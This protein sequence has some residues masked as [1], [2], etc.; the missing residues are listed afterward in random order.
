MAHSAPSRPLAVIFGTPDPVLSADQRA[1]FRDA[2]PLGLI[3][4]KRNCESPDQ[5][6]R[7]CGDFRDAV[8]RTDAPVLIDFEG[9]EHQRMEPPV[10]P[11]FPA[12]AAFGR[13]YAGDALAGLRAARLNGAAIGTLL[14]RHGVTVDCAPLA[15]VPVAGADP[16]IG[17]RAFGTDPEVVTVLA[18]AFMDGM[19]SVG[20]TPIIKHIP[21]HGRALV[22]SHKDRPVVDTGLDMLDCTDFLPFARLNRTAPW[23][24]VAHVVYSAVDAANPASISRD[25]VQT[26]IRERIGFDGVLISDCIYMESLGGTLAERAAAVQGAGVDIVLSSHGDVDEWIPIAAAV[27]PLGHAAAARLARPLPPAGAMVDVEATLLEI[28]MLLEAA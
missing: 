15:D 5:V 28:R 26:I 24:M 6:R 13:L 10:W 1:F 8:G 25:V 27:K 7:L 19:A 12:P 2:D 21:G 17:E 18:R 16:V 11:A 20:V 4:F 23:A 22:D 3:L 9:G 14:R